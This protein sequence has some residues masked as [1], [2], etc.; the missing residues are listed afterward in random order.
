MDKGMKMKIKKNNFL[1]SVP[2]MRLL[3]LG[4]IFYI[5]LGWV[6]L[7][8]PFVKNVRISSLDTL[9]TVVSAV[10]TTGLIVKDTATDFNFWGQLI[11][12][13]LIQVGGLGYMTFGSFLILSTKK[14]LSEVR[15]NVLS[16]SFSLPK[17]F[18][19]KKFVKSI[20]LYT[21]LIEFIGFVF[22]FFL[23]EEKSILQRLWSSFF[24]SISAFCTA[25][26][27]IY[28]DS[29]VRYGQNFWINAVLSVLSILG[30][31]GYIVAIDFLLM[32]KGEKSSITFTSKIILRMTGILLFAGT[33]FIFI[34]EPS[35]KGYNADTR[36]IFS[37]FQAMSSL[38]TV[39]F[40]SVNIGDLSLS[41]LL[42][43]NIF[44]II[45][46]S[47]SGTGGGIKSTTVS[48]VW[49]LLSSIMRNEKNIYY[50]G[51]EIPLERVIY[52]VCS[53][54]FYILILLSGVFLISMTDDFLL[55]DIFFESAS[56]LG[57][58]G[59]STGISAG[60]SNIGKIIITLLMFIGRLGPVSFG[61]AIF[62]RFEEDDDNDN[63][64]VV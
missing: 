16:T 30:A 28:S 37:F 32:L 51:K 8:L 22:L 58:V 3:L 21:V 59:L 15:K 36:L 9:Y 60:F 26:F 33:I 17:H 18:S 40:N 29:I 23:F 49:G 27:S 35:L 31:I 38:T 54:T 13:M 2:P 11:I 5:C 44:M 10:S 46:A 12:L 24:H 61:M 57:T 34:Y 52:A 41:V 20:V 63:D 1:D 14:D 43:V 7:S 53:F 64:I 50:M 39:G 56:A 55:K 45:G 48:A 6:F 47:P 62:Y 4:Y 19:I 42:L 25:G